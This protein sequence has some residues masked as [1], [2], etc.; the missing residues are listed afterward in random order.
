MQRYRATA[1]AILEKLQTDT[2]AATEQAVAKA[3]NR[4]AA[5]ATA[6]IAALAQAPLATGTGMAVVDSFA[7]TAVA[8]EL[9]G[10][11]ANTRP[12]I[13]RSV[14]DIYRRV[15]SD[16]TAN[17]LLGATTRRQ[18]AET[19]LQ[20]FARAGISGYTDGNGRRWELTSYVESAT[21]ASLM[22]AATE[23]HTQR[24]ESYGFDL[25][26]V[27]DVPQECALCLVPGTTVEGPAPTW[28]TR[29]EYRGDV[30]RIVTA[31]GKDLTGTPDHTVLTAGGWVA[32]KNLRPGDQVISNTRQQWNSGVMPNDIQV[33][34]LIEEVGE[35][36]V[37]LLL[38]GPARRDLD[39]DVAYR[40]VRAVFPDRDLLLEEC[41][42]LCE[43]FGDLSFI[44]AVGAAAASTSGGGLS[45]AAEGLPSGCSVGGFKHG[46]SL[47]GSS[48]GPSGPHGFADH[49][50]P[51]VMAEAGHMADDA[52]ML[53]ARLNASSAKVVTDYPSADAE[54]GAEL[55]RGFPGDVALDEIVSLSVSE[56][57][58][59]VWDLTTEPNW[60]LAN[61]IVTHNCRPWEGKKLSLSGRTMGVQVVQGKEIRVEGTLAE[62]KRAGLLHPNCRHSYSLWT[63]RTRSFGETADPEGDKARQK[64]RYLERCV[65]AAR[66]EELAAL[67]PEGE[68][69]ARQKVAAYQ[70]KIRE[71]VAT[72]SA[73]R[74]PH[75]ERLTAAR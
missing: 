67:T 65:R 45:L 71:H 12:N 44:G 29:S 28:R 30:I 13:F 52:V 66:R 54:G 63:P 73:K 47:I 9:T 53:G 14:N 5:A 60:F 6:D 49:R 36:V 11:L 21:R 72:T 51:L 34:T 8:A 56:F 2:P 42:A 38:S 35:S 18:A 69:K 27:S 46:G 58:G 31:S 22:N 37:P 70:S 61:G 40:E 64:L 16:V 23:G 43:P 19:A 17:A 24:L 32:L 62:A 50:G 75:R 25:V 48:V 4:G 39:Q 3:V 57:S 55:L 59:H 74:Q 26:V 1:E 10:V 7:A 20:R 33:P 68:R 41:A 15:I